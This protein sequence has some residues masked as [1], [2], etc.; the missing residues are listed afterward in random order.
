MSSKHFS[1]PQPDTQ[2]FSIRRDRTPRYPSIWHDH[3]EME[4]VYVIRGAGTLCIGDSIQTIQEGSIVLIPSL[5]PHYW[6]FEERTMTDRKLPEINCLV[7]HFR[8]DMGIPNILH[9]PEFHW[10]RSFTSDPQH[11]LLATANHAPAFAEYMNAALNESG[12]ERLFIF[13]KALRCLLEIAGQPLLSTSYSLVN[14]R[15]DQARMNA[16]MEYIRQNFRKQI[17]LSDLATVAGLTPNSCSRYFKQK[18]GKTPI[19]F[20]NELRISHACQQL[21]SD[22]HNLKTVCYDSGFNNFVSFYKL[23]KRLKGMTPRQFRQRW[24]T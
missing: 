20:I 4:L 11:G 2:S 21:I 9:A 5:T 23:F 3:Q 18:T 15:G 7:A 16:V 10:L 24:K 13:F 17:F 1:I 14:P 8:P 6:L 22:Q 19:Q 12:L